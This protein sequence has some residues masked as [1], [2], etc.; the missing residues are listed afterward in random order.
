VAEGV[1]SGMGTVAFVVIGSAIIIGWVLVN[2]AAP[3]LEQ[4]VGTVAHR[5]EFDADPWILLNLIF[6]GRGLL[7]RGTGDH[8]PEGADADRQGQRGGLSQ[9]P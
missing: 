6:L 7:Q 1:A 8:R 9:A 3:H 2:S 4:T 5:R